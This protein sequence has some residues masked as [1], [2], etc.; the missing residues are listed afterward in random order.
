MIDIIHD[1]TMGQGFPH[2]RAWTYFDLYRK[3]YEEIYNTCFHCEKN[4]FECMMLKQIASQRRK[5]L[6]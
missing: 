4:I 3:N 2:V 6:F 5:I 1:K